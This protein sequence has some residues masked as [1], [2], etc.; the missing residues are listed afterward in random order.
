MRY[1]ARLLCCFALMGTPVFAQEPEQ[2]H[3][4]LKPAKERAA[5]DVSPFTPAPGAEKNNKPAGNSPEQVQEI[6]KRSAEWLKTCL[7]D[8]D[9]NPY[10]QGRMADYLSARI[11]RARAVPSQHAGS[12]FNRREK[13][14]LIGSLREWICPRGRADRTAALGARPGPSAQLAA[15]A[16]IPK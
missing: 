6:K 1:L 4:V 5:T 10:Q 3:V 13:L 2:P 8:W 15:A 16:P 7:G 12:H 14:P 9:A 11:E